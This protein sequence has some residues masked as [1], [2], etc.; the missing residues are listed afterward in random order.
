MVNVLGLDIGGANT[1]A[2]CIQTIEEGVI[3]DVSVLVEYFPVWKNPQSLVHVLRKIRSKVNGSLDVVGVTM[4]AE[5]SDSYRTKR[6][7]VEHILGCVKEV[8]SD[9]PIYVL[10]TNAKLELFRGVLVEPLGVAAANWAATGWLVSQYFENCLVVDVGSTSTSIVPVIDGKVAAQGRTDFDKLVCG[11][12]VYTGSLRT[13]LAAIVQTVPVRGGGLST[14][15]SE[16]FALS[17]DVHLVLGNICSEQYTCETADGKGVTYKEALTRLARLVCADM[18]MLTE[19]ELLEI[20]GYIYEKQVQQIAK[21]LSQVYKRIKD[22]ATTKV[23]ILTAGLGKDFLAKKAAEQI[24]AVDPIMDLGKLLPEKVSLA[25]PAVGVA[26]MTA[27]Q[28]EPET[29]GN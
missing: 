3:G 20:A 15:S 2:A 28:W 21:G 26:L 11:E 9:L 17:A 1:K 27:K 13:N 25:V 18:E 12:L 29:R 22:V 6:E 16:L 8:F 7:G 4:T 19:E 23:P 5:L 10:N 14:V 24:K